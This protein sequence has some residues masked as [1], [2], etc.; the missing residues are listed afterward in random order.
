MCLLILQIFCALSIT[1]EPY[2]FSTGYVELWYQI[3]S[4]AFYPTADTIQSAKTKLEYSYRC[5]VISEADNDSAVKESI[6]RPATL[7]R[8]SREPVVDYIPL[9]LAPGNYRYRI[10]FD[11]LKERSVASGAVEVSSDTAAY[12]GSDLWLGKLGKEYFERRGIKFSA[13]LAPEYSTKD[14]MLAYLEIYGPVIDSINYRVQYEITDRNNNVVF[15]QSLNRNKR[16]PVQVDTFAAGLARLPDG[17]YVFRYI[18]TLADQ[19]VVITRHK[20]FTMRTAIQDLTFYSEPQYIATPGESKKLREFTGQ[21][22][23]DFLAEFWKKHNYHEYERRIIQ[24]DSLFT[25]NAA[26]GRDTDR[27]K[28]MIKTGPPD[29]I[30]VMPHEKWAKPIELWFYYARGFTAIFC[31]LKTD[32]NPRL[33]KEI[34]GTQIAKESLRDMKWLLDVAPGSSADDFTTIDEERPDLKEGPHD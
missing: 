27:G 7:E 6:K 14:Y 33:V 18:A 28:Y 9:Y 1:V 17:V 32:N 30:E 10:E 22:R 20:P 8:Y 19:G 2:R 13:A 15:Q 16:N 5:V 29:E 24:A 21:A 4:S 25:I 31:D 3:P 11:I 12:Y 34:R 26:K 23:D